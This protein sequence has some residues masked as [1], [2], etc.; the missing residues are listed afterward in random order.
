MDRVRIKYKGRHRSDILTRQATAV[1]YLFQL[2]KWFS[3]RYMSAR[4]QNTKYQFVMRP[5][6]K[7][8]AGIHLRKIC[9]MDAQVCRC[10]RAEAKHLD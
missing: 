6:L 9:G 2:A 7:F 5:G 8:H 10:W 3:G 1:L 4:T